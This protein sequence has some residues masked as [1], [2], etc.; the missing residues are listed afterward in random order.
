MEP[1]IIGLGLAWLAS[2]IVL[3]VLIRVERSRRLR[4]EVELEGHV[5]RL[6]SRMRDLELRL[7]EA[8]AT[9]ARAGGSEEPAPAAEPLPTVAYAPPPAQPAPVAQP[10]E[11]KAEPSA[12]AGPTEPPE[13]VLA[14]VPPDVAA[15]PPPPPPLP[16]PPSAPSP[17]GLQFD[18]ESLVGV[19]LLSWL[20]G[21][22]LLVAAAAVL[23]YS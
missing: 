17:R 8:E 1:L 11:P 19:R 5:D 12:P 2:P 23:L 9:V 10:P 3:F 21:G 14:G 18:W 16:P 20:A 6:T 15:E 13:P 7:D 22:T 4:R